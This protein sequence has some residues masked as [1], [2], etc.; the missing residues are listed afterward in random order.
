M[1]VHGKKDNIDV[2]NEE[3]FSVVK[4]IE[5]D[6]HYVIAMIEVNS[7]FIVASF[8]NYVLNIY[9]IATFD[10]LKSLKTTASAIKFF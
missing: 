6:K 9:N 8:K 2:V 3:D 1:Y 5:T 4:T 10:K 7:E